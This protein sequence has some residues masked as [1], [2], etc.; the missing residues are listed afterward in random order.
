MENEPIVVGWISDARPYPI[1]LLIGVP[2]ARDELI[3]P[4]ALV[5][6]QA[7]PLYPAEISARRSDVGVGSP[8]GK[9]NAPPFTSMTPVTLK[10]PSV[11]WTRGVLA[12]V[13]FAGIRS[14][15]PTNSDKSNTVSASGLEFP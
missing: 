14:V 2:A 8:R 7:P 15:P 1:P 12:S 9:S 13:A 4:A 10:R 6:F 11:V 5:P 3:A